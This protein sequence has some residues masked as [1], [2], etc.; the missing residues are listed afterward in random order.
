MASFPVKGLNTDFKLD[1]F[2]IKKNKNGGK[3]LRTE[4]IKGDRKMYWF[5]HYS[6]VEADWSTARNKSLS[7]ALKDLSTALGLQPDTSAI[8][9]LKGRDAYEAY[10]EAM[11]AALPDTWKGTVVDLFLHYQREPNKG[12]TRTYLEI[13]RDNEFGQIFAPSTSG[14]EWNVFDSDEDGIFWMN[15]QAKKHPFRRDDKWKR[16]PHFDKSGV[17]VVEP[18]K[19]TPPPQVPANDF[20]GIDDMPP[21]TSDDDLPF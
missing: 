20:P 17:D 3:Y 9:G 13:P 1:V 12:Q 6:D 4:W 21:M 2:T 11:V 16:S 18:P 15:K 7:A 8:A 14:Q 10:I 5:A 19:T